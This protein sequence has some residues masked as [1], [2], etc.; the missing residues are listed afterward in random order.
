MDLP[1]HA[2]KTIDREAVQADSKEVQE[3]NFAASKILGRFLYM[4][5]KK[6]RSLTRFED[7]VATLDQCRIQVGEINHSRKFCREIGSKIYMLLF[8]KII[9]KLSKPLESTSRS[10]P[11]SILFDGYT[12]KRIGEQIISQVAFLDG[13][14]VDLNFDYKKYTTDVTAVGIGNVIVDSMRSCFPR[15]LGEDEED[16]L[17]PRYYNYY[18]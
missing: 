2:E 8:Q 15:P 9:E 1:S 18:E 7:Y 10:T 17:K 3:R 11:F 4:A 5:I 16:A 14:I 12:T 6:D 13:K